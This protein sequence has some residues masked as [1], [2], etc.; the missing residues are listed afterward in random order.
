MQAVLTP[1]LVSY[2]ALDVVLAVATFIQPASSDEQAELTSADLLTGGVWVLFVLVVVA[3]IVTFARLLMRSNVNA[4]SFGRI[5]GFTPASMVWWY[6]VPLLSLVKPY[7]AFK[8]VWQA[9][10]DG[11]FPEKH[12]QMG[13]WWGT[14]I[15]SN[16]L[17]NISWRLPDDAAAVFGLVAAPATVASAY[18]AI[19]VTRALTERQEATAMARQSDTTPS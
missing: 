1:L 7:E 12:P 3:T 6:F 9:S 17:G 2:A 8:A 5:L 14:W 18:F 10:G 11:D 16:I 19:V 13:W 4:R 15:V